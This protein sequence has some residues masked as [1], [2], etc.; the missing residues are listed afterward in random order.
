M[1]ARLLPLLIVLMAGVLLALGFPLGASVAAQEQQT[2]VID[3]I[4]DTAR[5][6]SLAQFVT[7]RGTGSRVSTTDERRETL[8]Q[9]LSRYHEVYGI[10]AGCLLPRRRAHGQ[11]PRELGPARTGR[12]P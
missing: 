12:R 11:R 10:R 6:A 7:A 1:R 2:V 4:D 9:E 8:Q 3:R 5:F